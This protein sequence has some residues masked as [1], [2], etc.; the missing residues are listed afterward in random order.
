MKRIIKRQPPPEYE[1]W[2]KRHPGESFR[3]LQG[4]PKR[5]LKLSLLEEQYWVCGYCGARVAY[6]SAH[7]EHIIPHRTGTGRLDYKNLIASC[8]GFTGARENCGHKKDDLAIK[9]SPLD[10]GC[11]ARFRYLMSGE[12]NAEELD[13]VET[14]SILNL[15]APD[16][17]KA[18]RAVI[19]AILHDEEM[20]ADAQAWAEYYRQPHSGR[21]EP[22][23]MAAA[24]ALER[25]I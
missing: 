23:C 9:V 15:N 20:A 17:V 6:D 4:R 8:N 1:A 21:L 25:Y 13:A 7:I 10:E 12:M 5:A 14:I 3:K 18:R 22:F 16:L 2:T 19:S 24:Y 11:E